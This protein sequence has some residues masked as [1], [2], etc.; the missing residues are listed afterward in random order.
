MG[1]LLDV[2][3]YFLE[4]VLDEL[5]ELEDIVDLG[6]LFPDLICD[7]VFAI[8]G[9]VLVSNEDSRLPDAL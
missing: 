1:E 7:D 5:V 9:V 6:D 8:G 2:L 3:V 4:G